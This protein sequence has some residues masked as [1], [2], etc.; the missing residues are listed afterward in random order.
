MPRARE[1]AYQ[2]HAG[3]EWGYVLSG[4]LQVRIGFQEYIL[5]PGDAISI[6]SSIPHRL[7]TIGDVPVEAVWF[8]LGRAQFDT[9]TLVD[10]HRPGGR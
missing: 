9:Q 6:D 10:E 8:V 2:R 4:R 3:H 5:E 7:A 1:S